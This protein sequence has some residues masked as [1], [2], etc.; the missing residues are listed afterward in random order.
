M[1]KGTWESMGLQESDT[2][3]QPSAH[4]Q[5]DLKSQKLQA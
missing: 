3:E 5:Y 2:T 1:D 4:T